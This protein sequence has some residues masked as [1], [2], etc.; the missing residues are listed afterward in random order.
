MAVTQSK[1]LKDLRQAVGRNLGK[2]ITGGSTSTAI[3]TSLFG[4][5]DEYIGSYMRFT[6]GNKNG[7]TQRISDYTSSSTTL[8]FKTTTS[9]AI[10][11]DDTYELWGDGF[12]PD[13]VDE[14]INQSIWEVTG[15]VYDPVENLDVHTDRINTRWEIPSGLAMI[16]DVYYRDKITQKLLHNCNSSFTATNEGGGT[17]RGADGST[18]NFID[19][20]DYKTGSGANKFVITSAS[21]D[22]GLMTDSITSVNLAKYDYIEFW[23]KSNQNTTAAGDLQLMLDNTAACASPLET[24]NIPILTADTWKYCRLALSNPE[25]ATAI[26]SVGLKLADSSQVNSGT[27]TIWIDDIKAVKN[28]TAAW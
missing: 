2:M 10:D 25:T 18:T 14:L 23:I 5:D 4:G 21:N 20:E 1:T 27:A 3:D 19:T 11:G 12:D 6:S 22:N 16:Q 28:D 17:I 15:R 9:G 24:L 7:T 13:V 8:T 26:I